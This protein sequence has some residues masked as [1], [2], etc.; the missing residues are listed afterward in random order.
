MSDLPPPPPP[1][2]AGGP[3]QPYLPP[4]PGRAPRDGP[5]PAPGG[6]NPAQFSPGY[7]APGFSPSAGRPTRSGKAV[8]GFVLG[9]CSILLF[10]TCVVPFL[11]IVF[12]L[13][14][15]REVKRSD[16]RKTGLAMARWGWTLGVLGLIGG[17]GAWVVIA[18]E[19]AGTTDVRSLEVGDCVDL[20]DDGDQNVVRVATHPC[21]EAHEAEVFSV[22][23]LGDGSDPYPGQDEV[24]QTIF[25]NCIA[26]LEDYVGAGYEGP[27][28]FIF[29]IYPS[30][31][32][33]RI[34]QE[35]VCLAQLEDRVPLTESIKDAGR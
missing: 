1:G 6:Y 22:G 13:L 11:A 33:W 27:E 2:T 19:I 8:T 31:A 24:D 16:G 21:D 18:S 20:P 23:D 25:D 12:G 29:Q 3:P 10:I 26:D 4:A 32:N 17:I 14:G 35:Y 5:A 15:A 28:L 30:E 34:D 9:L 7:G